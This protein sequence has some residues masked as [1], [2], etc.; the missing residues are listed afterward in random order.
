MAEFFHQEL[1]YQVVGLAFE[2]HKA[3]GRFGKERDYSTAM[4]SAMK[5]AGVPY[6]RVGVVRRTG[7]R[8]NYVT[9]GKI[10]L[11]IRAKKYMLMDDYHRIRKALHELDLPLAL[12]L[13]FKNPSIQSIRVYKGNRP[14]GTPLPTIQMEE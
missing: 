9:D 8:I 5:A 13:N 12:V 11:V 6:R 2:V 10:A 14:P 4:E 3:V 1:S 7:Y